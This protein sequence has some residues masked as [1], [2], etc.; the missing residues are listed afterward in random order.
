MLRKV[1]CKPPCR[2][3]TFDIVEKSEIEE[4]VDDEDEVSGSDEHKDTFEL[5]IKS[6]EP[7]RSIRKTT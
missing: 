4:K 5:S 3:S 1:G 7:S 6:P 2:I